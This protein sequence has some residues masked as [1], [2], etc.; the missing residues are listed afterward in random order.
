[1]CSFL[2]SNCLFTVLT[3]VYAVNVLSSLI[4]VFTEIL[5]TSCLF[6][7]IIQIDIKYPLMY[8]FYMPVVTQ[9][10]KICN[11]MFNEFV[12]CLQCF[13]KNFM[14]M[15]LSLRQTLTFNSHF[16]CIGY[17]CL[18]GKD[19]FNTLMELDLKMINGPVIMFCILIYK[20]AKCCILCV[21][22]R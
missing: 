11:V 8:C 4:S 5:K 14:L 12:N 16:I 10:S 21:A 19:V 20:C 17:M 6:I 1:M 3:F 18:D 2:L 15:T 22:M 13:L 7:H 9:N